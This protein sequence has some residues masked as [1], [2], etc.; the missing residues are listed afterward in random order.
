MPKML[1]KIEEEL[2]ASLFGDV[3]TGAK[4]KLCAAALKESPRFCLE[5]LK[6]LPKDA[7]TARQYNLADS[8][9]GGAGEGQDTMAARALFSGSLAL[10]RLMFG[11]QRRGAGQPKSQVDIDASE[12]A[13]A[14]RV[15]HLF[16][17]EA[18]D[19]QAL[20]ALAWIGAPS[21]QLSPANV[22]RR[23]ERDARMALACGRPSV[24][25][26]LCER[27]LESKSEDIARATLPA[28]EHR[29]RGHHDPHPAL[30]QKPLEWSGSTQERWVA[31]IAWDKAMPRADPE[32]SSWE[33]LGVNCVPADIQHDSLLGLGDLWVGLLAGAQ[34]ERS[35]GHHA[36]DIAAAGERLA[37]LCEK[38]WA[39]GALSS[40]SDYAKRFT[41]NPFDA[42][43]P[44]AKAL[45]SGSVE[46]RLS[47]AHELWRSAAMAATTP[48]GKGILWDAFVEAHQGLALDIR[49]NPFHAPDSGQCAAFWSLAGDG[50]LVELGIER[51][52]DP[53][54]VDGLLVAEGF[55]G[56]AVMSERLGQPEIAFIEPAHG[57]E[58]GKIRLG[59]Q[60][61]GAFTRVGK[62]LG[63]P[64]A[65]GAPFSK[66]KSFLSANFSTVALLLG[67]EKAAAALVSAGAASPNTDQGMAEA[68]S[69]QQTRA[70]KDK[71]LAKQA[72]W[73]RAA[74]A[75]SVD[76]A[77][78]K[79][80]GSCEPSEKAARKSLRI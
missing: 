15:M 25:L 61:K 67:L 35:M 75:A 43:A 46:Q 48:C 72:L 52:F 41:A 70:N 26:A 7:F 34:Q 60:I 40:P 21:E 6:S 5:L 29:R 8:F 56:K 78:R 10:S 11:R 55:L 53:K 17:G 76:H 49:D 39:K 30:G 36:Q 77:N 1:R 45:G 23:M 24:G 54:P 4:I 74:L 51:G 19:K 28:L 38:L 69:Q 2:P 59:L 31:K 13:R 63:K 33:R 16:G 47:T 62:Q 79:K 9:R 64:V 18:N 12:N 27:L 44:Q 32:A 42:D 73:E 65:A 71:I 22:A 68:L 58:R 20:K 57:V 37:A 50:A 14:E 80:E 66:D 3:S